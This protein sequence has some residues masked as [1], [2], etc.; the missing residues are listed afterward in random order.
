MKRRLLGITSHPFIAITRHDKLDHA[1]FTT[2]AVAAQVCDSEPA[3][4][5]LL[6]PLEISERRAALAR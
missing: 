3:L 2:E 1:R 5:D 4:P 6:T